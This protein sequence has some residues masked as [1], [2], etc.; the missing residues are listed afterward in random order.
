MSTL[1]AKRKLDNIHYQREQTPVSRNDKVQGTI[2]NNVILLRVYNQNQ[3][4]HDA[5]DRGTHDMVP[6][7]PGLVTVPG[8]EPDKEHAHKIRSNN[9]TLGLDRAVAEFVDEL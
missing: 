3:V 4:S 5:N 1:Y 8:L 6:P 7:V 2:R 9:E